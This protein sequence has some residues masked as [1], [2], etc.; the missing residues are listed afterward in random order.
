MSST[1]LTLAVIPAIYGLVKQFELEAMDAIGS[2]MHKERSPVA[3]GWQETCA[4]LDAA[5]RHPPRP[6]T[7][8]WCT[9]DSRHSPCR[10]PRTQ[11]P[12]TFQSRYT[13]PALVW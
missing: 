8:L 7:N 6:S 9:T 5:A 11:W 12:A 10:W 4:L 3:S 13:R 1:A 2:R